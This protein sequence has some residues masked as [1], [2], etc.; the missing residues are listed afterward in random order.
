MLP[1]HTQELLTAAVD[2]EL[3]HAERRMVDILLRDSAEARAFHARLLEDAEKLRNAPPVVPA[4]DLASGIMA[5]I[6][7]RGMR[8]TPLPTRRRNTAWN[9]SQFLPWFSVATAALVLIAVSIFSY[10]FFAVNQPN[11]SDPAKASAVNPPNSQPKAEPNKPKRDEPKFEEPRFAEMAPNPREVEPRFVAKVEPRIDPEMLPNPRLLGPMDLL[12]S[13]EPP[14]PQRF[15]VVPISLS[16][17]LPLRDLDQPYPR[18]QLRD[19]LMKDE[20]FRL[21]LFC[22]DSTRA[23]DLLQLALKARGQQVLVEAVAQDRLKKRLKT[24]YVFFTE[25]LTGEEIALLLETLGVNDRKAEEKKAGD[26]QFDKFLLTPFIAQDALELS[27]LLGVRPNN[28][29]LPKSK[30]VLDPGKSLESNT[31]SQIASTLPKGGASRNERMTLVLAGEPAVRPETSK[32]I[33]SFLDKRSDRKPGTITL[34]LVL[35]PLN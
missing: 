33:K 18:K 35:R 4:D 32:E 26:G 3:T 29:K 31:A 9:S 25:T 8:P 20:I 23:A 10:L 27:K 14:E 17:L 21:D 28:L 12:A 34:M 19:E 1:A 5:I 6:N 15:K 11:Q 22:R 7:E 30:V 2:G 13:P 24:E 16:L